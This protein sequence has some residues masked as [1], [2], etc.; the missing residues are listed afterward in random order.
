MLTGFGALGLLW[1]Q[2]LGVL[3]FCRFR[4]YRAFVGL[5]FRAF[6]GLGFRGLGF[7]A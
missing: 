7:R 6:V 2:G 3:G 5:G 1:V 4:A